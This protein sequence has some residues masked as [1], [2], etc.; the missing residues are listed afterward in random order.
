MGINPCFRCGSISGEKDKYCSSCS[1][2]LINRCTND[3]GLLG[4]PCNKTLSSYA[5]YCTDCGSYTTF[6]Q[7]GLLGT[8]SM[9]KNNQEPELEYFNHFTNRFFHS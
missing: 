8:A 1:S 6:Y 5:V 9:P 2:P 3:G 7:E 4:E